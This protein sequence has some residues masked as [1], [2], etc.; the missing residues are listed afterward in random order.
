MFLR[1]KSFIYPFRIFKVMIFVFIYIYIYIFTFI[2]LLLP[3]ASEFL[4]P[5]DCSF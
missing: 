1:K 2:F 5:G 4:V 3:A